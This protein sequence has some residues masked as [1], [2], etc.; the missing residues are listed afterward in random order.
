MDRRI[1]DREGLAAAPQGYAVTPCDVHVWMGRLGSGRAHV[2]AMSEI[3]S[4]DERQ[5]A[6]RFH[7]QADRERLVV[8]R[9]LARIVL[10]HLL[11]IR[12]D[13][14]QFCYNDFGKP[15]LAPAQNSADFQFNVSHSGDIVLFAVTARRAVGVDVEQIR[16]NLEVDAIAARFFSTRER[17]DLAAVAADQRCAAFFACW[18]RK[19]AF[20]KAGGVGL[21]RGLDS[22][23]VSLKPDEPAMLLQTRPDPTEAGRWVIRDLDVGPRYKAALAVEGSICELKTLDW[24]PDPGV[25]PCR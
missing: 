16:E 3:L 17:A 19:E 22:F 14:I 23:D 25:P 10:G 11:D 24:R 9:A 4:P 20:I 7:F 15:S 21:L 5:R 6:E 8:G 12:S 2:E 18:S 13:E 1:G